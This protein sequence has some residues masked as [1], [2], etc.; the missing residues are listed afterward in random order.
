MARSLRY[1]VFRRTPGRLFP[2]GPHAGVG[3]ASCADQ[4][5]TPPTATASATQKNPPEVDDA[6]KRFQMRDFDGALKLLQEAVKKH[7]DLPPAQFIMA[8]LFA[9]VN[10]AGGMRVSL[11]KA[12]MSNPDDPQAY[13]ALG[14][15]ALQEHRIT[16]AALLYGKANELLKAVPKDTKRKDLVA[17]EPRCISGLAAVAEARE[18]WR[19]RRNNWKRW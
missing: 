3:R 9:A 2:V 15:I 11:E 17:L 1:S 12:V 7:S 6:I 16:E 13:A 19:R 10:Q 18:N 4:V 5:P 8:Q 14:D